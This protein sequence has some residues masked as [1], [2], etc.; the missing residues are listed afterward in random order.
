M[1]GTKIVAKRVTDIF[2]K[3]IIRAADSTFDSIDSGG[4]EVQVSEEVL[5]GNISL[6]FLI[7][8]SCAPARILPVFIQGSAVYA[9]KATSFIGEILLGNNIQYEVKPQSQLPPAIRDWLVDN[10]CQ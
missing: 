3:G 6:I 2:L 1:K 9:N 8:R 5:T 4:Y 7:E 10:K